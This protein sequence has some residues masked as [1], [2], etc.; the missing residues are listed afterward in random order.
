MGKII[1]AEQTQM[2]ACQAAINKIL[3][4]Y[5]FTF[6]PYFTCIGGQLAQGV[7]LVKNTQIMDDDLK[8]AMANPGGT[9][10]G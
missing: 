1:T 10:G 2:E 5:G 4:Q 9:N 7:N 6:Q 8:R 3:L